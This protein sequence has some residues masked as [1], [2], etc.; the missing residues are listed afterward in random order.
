MM[1]AIVCVDNNWAI[2]NQNNLLF[3]IKE[4]MARFK[5]ITMDKTIVYGRKT[6]ESFPGK[7][8]LPGRKNIVMTRDFNHL[9]SK[10][11]FAA[12]YTGFFSE[13]KEG[14]SNP[15]FNDAEYRASFA[16]RSN[17]DVKVPNNRTMIFWV[18]NLRTLL[19]TVEIIGSSEDTVICG[20]EQI[21]RLL[22]P[23]YDTVYVTKV[24]AEAPAHDATF[25]NLDEMDDW[26]VVEDEDWRSNGSYNF[27]FMTYKRK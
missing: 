3:N 27:K 26:K 22:L 24:D 21:Y 18:E 19:D 4:D 7:K 5:D 20:G 8:P 17:P 11:L 14:I 9:E 25:P 10:S 15:Y 23:Y 16:V 1:K 2:G 12:K 6:L 13:K